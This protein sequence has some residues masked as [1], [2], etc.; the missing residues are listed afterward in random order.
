VYNNDERKELLAMLTELGKILRKIRIDRQEL[1]RD[2][3]E[4]LGVSAAYL[5]AVENGKRNAPAAWIDKIIQAYRL[6]PDE[7]KQLRSA[8]DESKDELRIS[9]QRVSA[10]QRNTAISFAKA[11][12]GL[13]DEELE[14]IMKVVQKASKKE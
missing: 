10:Q 7:A 2:M 9:L 3:A 6:N 14:R 5:S 4:T 11:L 12:E 1:L 13:S 8:F